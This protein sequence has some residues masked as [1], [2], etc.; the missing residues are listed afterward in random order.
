M[1]TTNVF[2]TKASP[3]AYST[4]FLFVGAYYYYQF[5]H[6]SD[7]TVIDGVP[8]NDVSSIGKVDWGRRKNTDVET[9]RGDQSPAKRGREFEGETGG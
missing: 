1:H 9:L 6:D 2:A 4:G 3:N 5:L 7:A 8:Y